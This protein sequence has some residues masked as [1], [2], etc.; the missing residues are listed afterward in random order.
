MSVSEGYEAASQKLIISVKAAL[1]DIDTE[2][3]ER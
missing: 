2:W 3:E 1:G